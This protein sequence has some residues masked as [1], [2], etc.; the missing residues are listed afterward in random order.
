[1]ETTVT[2]IGSSISLS[3]GGF[4]LTFSPAEQNSSGQ[5]EKVR[6]FLRREDLEGLHATIGSALTKYTDP[7]ASPRHLARPKRK[8]PATRRQRAH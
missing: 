4:I 2:V 8:V 3:L 6:L 5:P 1:M 7:P